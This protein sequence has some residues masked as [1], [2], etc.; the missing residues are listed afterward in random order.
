MEHFADY[1]DHAS[2]ELF[3]DNQALSWLLKSNKPAGRLAFWLV[4][5]FRFKFD[6]HHIKGKDNLVADVLSRMFCSGEYEVTASDTAEIQKINVVNEIVPN[7]VESVEVTG[8]RSKVKMDTGRPGKGRSYHELSLF[9]WHRTSD[10]PRV[11]IDSQYGLGAI[12]RN[13]TDMV[14]TYRN[15]IEKCISHSLSDCYGGLIGDL[16][17]TSPK[18]C[19][20][21]SPDG[22]CYTNYISSGCWALLRL[23]PRPSTFATHDISAI[24]MR[25]EFAEAQNRQGKSIPL[26]ADDQGRG[27]PGLLHTLVVT[28]EYLGRPKKNKSERPIRRQRLRHPCLPVSGS[29]PPPLCGVW[30]ITLFPL[31][32]L[33]DVRDSHLTQ[34][35]GW[36]S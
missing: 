10:R 36:K 35:A 23:G 34:S 27:M 16:T 4:R 13:D 8:S 25:G 11:V 14:N 7:H 24:R 22:D 31:L 18:M 26:K 32:P 20:L 15:D 9:S 21:A 3:T 28:S 17:P 33:H 29:A 30:V 12:Y 6:V 19:A 5:L 2:F 1:L